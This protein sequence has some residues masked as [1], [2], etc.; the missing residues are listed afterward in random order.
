MPGLT[1]RVEQ[2]TKFSLKGSD[3]RT[4]KICDEIC[5]VASSLA[6]VLHLETRPGA[7]KS[8]KRQKAVASFR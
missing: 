8:R 5:R 7:G 2:T 6:T 3:F 1:E 4:R